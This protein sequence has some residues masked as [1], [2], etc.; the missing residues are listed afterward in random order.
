ME[1]MVQDAASSG[2]KEQWNPSLEHASSQVSLASY[3]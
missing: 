1:H 2:V 3:L